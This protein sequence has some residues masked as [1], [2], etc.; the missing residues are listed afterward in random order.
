MYNE[1]AEEQRRYYDITGGGKCLH[2]KTVFIFISFIVELLEG[3]DFLLISFSLS[4]EQ[5]NETYQ[6]STQQAYWRDASIAQL[7]TV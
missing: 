4:S 2:D 3:Q 6:S 1:Q 7:A 5:Q